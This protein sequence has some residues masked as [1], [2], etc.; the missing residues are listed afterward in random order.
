MVA[1]L[2]LVG[3]ASQGQPDDLVPQ[4]DPEDR[5]LA[6]QFP[7]RR[8]E[9]GHPF[10]ISRPVGEEDPV[11]LAAQDFL[12]GRRGRH[13]RDLAAARDELPQDVPLDPAVVGD[14]FIEPRVET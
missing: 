11:W 13:H 3:A 8:D 5:P 6:D 12:R 14:D 9:V 10:G 2:Q 7:H 4:T 1:E